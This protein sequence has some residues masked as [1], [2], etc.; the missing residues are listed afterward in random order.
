MLFAV[1]EGKANVV[2]VRVGH[3]TLDSAAQGRTFK[4]DKVARVDQGL[5]VT[6]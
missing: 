3:E 2:K 4:E 1:F 5:K 6:H